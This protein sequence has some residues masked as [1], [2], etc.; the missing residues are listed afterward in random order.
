MIR[1]TTQKAYAAIAEL[2]PFA[3]S[4]ALS[5][6]TPIGESFGPW[7]SGRLAREHVASFQH[8]S[9]A[10][11]SY[12]TPIAWVTDSHWVIPADRYSLTTSRHQSAA[13][14]GASVSGLNVAPVVAA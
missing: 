12:A 4:G 1:T 6:R 11:F 9:Y 14:Y 10:V 7:D 2:A 3:T 8:A 5:G 13:R